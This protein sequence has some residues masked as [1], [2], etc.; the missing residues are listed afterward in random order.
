MYSEDTLAKEIEDYTNRW[1]G[2]L[3]SWIGRIS[4]FHISVLQRQSMVSC[5]LYQNTNDSFFTELK[6]IVLKFLQNH[7]SI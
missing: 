2:I 1:K 7:K 3:C 4:I 6:Q 5:N